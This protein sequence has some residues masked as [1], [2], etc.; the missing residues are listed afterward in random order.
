MKQI[1]IISG[2]G[3]TGK[4]VITGAFA[5]LAKNKVMAD[6]DVDAADLHLLLNPD[7]KERHEFRSG[8]TAVIDRKLCTKCGKCISICRFDAITEDFTID[9]VYCEGCAFCSHICPADTIK[10]KENVVGEWF[11][12]D[13]RFGPMV[14]A[15]LGIAEENSGKLV[16]L[17]RKKAKEI[18]EQNKLDFVIV[19]GAPGIGCPVIASISGVDCALVIT[20]PTLSGL[21]D[22]DRV[23]KV[24]GHFGISAKLVVNKCDLNMDMTEKIEKYCADNNVETLGR[25]GF[26]KSIVDAMVNGK[27]I[28][29]YSDSKAKE[30]ITDIWNKLETSL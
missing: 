28:I 6:C 15:R 9:P 21:H 8:K 18:A 10:M 3:G 30:E 29:E 5:A 27:T 24:T 17:V 14:H 26:D 11:I 13:T 20:E 2:K 4:T 23:I 16:T 19:D 1:V 22:A 7:I 12:A 25:I